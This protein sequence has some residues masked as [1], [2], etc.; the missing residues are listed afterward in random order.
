MADDTEAI[1]EATR[2]GPSLYFPAGQYRLTGPIEI[3]GPISA[4]GQGREQSKIFSDVGSDFFRVENGSGVLFD[5]LG[6][7]GDYPNVKTGEVLNIRSCRDVTVRNCGFLNGSSAFVWI[8]GCQQVW[9][10]GN[11]LSRAGMG[12]IILG[13]SPEGTR[14]EWV[15]ISD[16]YIEYVQ[17][18]LKY[19]NAAIQGRSNLSA[20]WHDRHVFVSRNSIWHPGVVGI[21]MDANDDMLIDG[22]N[23]VS[24]QDGRG[25]SVAVTGENIRI[26]NNNL[27][28]KS[29]AA[30]CLL[31]A[32]DP[33]LGT[34]TR[35]ILITNNIMDHNNQPDLNQIVALA[36]SA[37]GQVISDVHVANNIFRNGQYA[38]QAYDEGETTGHG[39]RNLSFVSNML[40]GVYGRNVVNIDP[41]PVRE[42]IHIWNNTLEG[43]QL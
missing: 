27:L 22:N 31:W 36:T 18:E 20:P 3:D 12:G 8:R 16:N 5:G 7:I 42:G 37:D 28:N 9:V 1:R 26:T 25:E 39:I 32:A 29:G 40:Q 33:S 41:F 11:V 2:A 30:C 21:G 10:T 24:G 43:R 6:F 34:R 4:V 17:Q 14:N 23:V 38:L 15:W 35:N 13:R 19:G